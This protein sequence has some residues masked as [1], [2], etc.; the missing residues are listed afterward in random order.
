MMTKNE[1]SA[2]VKPY[3]FWLTHPDS[4][5]ASVHLAL[6]WV[7][8]VYPASESKIDATI[9]TALPHA[10]SA[11]SQRWQQFLNEQDVEHHVEA[12]RWLSHSLSAEQIP[13]L[14]ETCWRLLLIDH[15]LPAHTPLALRILAQALHIDESQVY[16]IGEHVAREC[17]ED[18]TSGRAPLLPINP[19]Y[20]DRVE[21]R[22]TGDSA[23]KRRAS[24]RRVVSQKRD[25]KVFVSFVFGVFVGF[26][27][28]LFVIFSPIAHDLLATSN[29]ELA[30]QPT[31]NDAVQQ[32]TLAAVDVEPAPIVDDNEASL[33]LKAPE[34]TEDD[35]VVA[36]EIT[37]LESIEPITAP[38]EQ[39][40]LNEPIVDVEQ[41]SL[42]VES[43][44][45]TET[46][47]LL[48]ATTQS[49]V[50]AVDEVV[51]PN[52]PAPA[53]RQLM[54]VTASILNMRELP[55]SNSAVVMKLGRSAEVWAYPDKADGLWMYIEV[56]AEAG[57]VSKR[58]LEPLSK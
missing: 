5:Q 55:S 48:E 32:P 43:T 28:T 45:T 14:I 44:L 6:Q 2:A 54:S 51:I 12:L 46:E 23:I 26:L 56:Q 53:E 57:Y 3:A 58:F 20:L 42:A 1:P 35:L 27:M 31:S 40:I 7:A 9:V 19:R 38:E 29:G 17:P 30:V 36:D 11:L 10:D 41:T 47:P 52:S 34:T 50:V 37:I 22:L 8:F 21:W 33:L 15:E 49:V 18:L 24:Q 16:E 4:T 25:P 39:L 13:F